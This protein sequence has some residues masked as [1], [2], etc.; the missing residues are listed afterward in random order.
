MTTLPALI[1]Y[2][3]RPHLAVSCPSVFGGSERRLGSVLSGAEQ[4]EAT[5]TGSGESD[6]ARHD[7]RRAERRFSF[8]IGGGSGGRVRGG[9]RAD[10][11][12]C[13]SAPRGA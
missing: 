2:A 3:R 11:I 12:D 4:I 9:V 1:S 5:V 10:A 6:R 7:L 8:R 13:A